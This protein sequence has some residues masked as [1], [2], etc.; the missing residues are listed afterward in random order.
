MPGLRDI[1]RREDARNAS[2]EA[3]RSKRSKRVPDS[4][5]Q[6]W[7]Q[8]KE[9]EAADR[10]RVAGLERRS[11]GWL[12]KAGVHGST[13]EIARRKGGDTESL[14]SRSDSDTYLPEGSV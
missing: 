10:E 5:S 4:G 7:E 2:A 9:A 12:G 11:Q 13:S 8:D 1:F 14:D 3:K 6:D